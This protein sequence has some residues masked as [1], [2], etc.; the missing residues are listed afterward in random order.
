MTMDRDPLLQQLF[1]LA[2][3]DLHGT[4]FIAGVMSQIDALRRRAIV[5]WI[6]AG[7]VLAVAAWLL[8]PTMV[9]AVGLLSQALPQSLV[10]VD[11]PPALVGHL[12]SPLNSIA[13]VVAVTVLVVVF[14]YRRLF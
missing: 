4:A 6:A 11:T 10:E 1:D 7:L 3:R 2:N 9:A 14:A 12:L 8:T 5:A 13:A